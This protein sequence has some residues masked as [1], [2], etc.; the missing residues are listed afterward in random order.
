M[1]QPSQ[2]QRLAAIYAMLANWDREADRFRAAATAAL[3]GETPSSLVVAAVEEAH[4]GLINLLDQMDRALAELASGSAEFA[5]MLRAQTMA[6]GL[7]ES[8]GT[9]LDRLDRYVADQVAGPHRIAH[10][11]VLVAAE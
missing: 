6:L 9:S 4:D 8:I 5:Q 2:D 10:E 7:L 1:F 3:R 11:P